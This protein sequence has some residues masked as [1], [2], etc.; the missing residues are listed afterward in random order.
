MVERYDVVIA[1]GAAMGSSL[2][3]HL[4]ADSG[5]SGRVL[6]IEKDLTYAKAASA[7]SASSIRQQFSTAINIRVSLHGIDFLRRGRELLAVDGD[8]PDIAVREKGYLY[9]ATAAGAGILAENHAL[10]I[11]EG[12]DVVLMT[13]AE[14][15]AR[16][17]YVATDDLAAASW[18]A[19]GEGWFDGYGLTQAFRRKARSLGVAYREA[20]VAG[21]AREG[22][23]VVAV[24]LGDGAVVACGAFVNCAGASGARAVA[25]LCGFDIPVE[26]RKRS[27]FQFSCPTPLPDLPLMIDVSG[28]WVR[29]E[30][31]GYIGAGVPEHDPHCEDFDVDWAQFEEQVWPALARRIPAFE[32]IRPGR[33]WAGHY[34]LNL[35][36]HNAIVGPMPGLDN[37]W[38]AAGF[39]GH[40]IQQA[41][42][43]GRGLAELIAHG[44]YR[45]LDLS[46]FAFDRIAAGRPILE[47]NVI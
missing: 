4:A 30:G 23:R 16:F 11:A 34:D 12:A 20:A 2:A 29:P 24:T 35:F 18:G 32:Q 40:G 43:I 31:E 21:L 13:P 44:R 36:D 45:A 47:R 39:S 42:A 15:S 6:V 37:A 8:V 33:A 28:V 17:P 3:Y 26:S 27:V 22:R 19:S 38:L 7:L 41:P 25:Q 10:Q 46:D 5:F 1:G 14:L 9:L